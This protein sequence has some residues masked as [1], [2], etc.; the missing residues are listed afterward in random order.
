M[1]VG[2][3]VLTKSPFEPEVC[4]VIGIREDVGDGCFEVMTSD[5]KSVTYNLRKNALEVISESRRSS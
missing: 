2:D 1:K 3:L 4:L 5:G